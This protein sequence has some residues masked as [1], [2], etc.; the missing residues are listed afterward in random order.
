MLTPEEI[1]AFRKKGE[2]F[3]QQLW[4]SN[5]EN[6]MRQEA[7]QKW[8]EQQRAQGKIFNHNI[9]NWLDGEITTA[10]VA[11]VIGMILTALIKGQVVIWAIMYLA[12]RLRIKKV[13]QGAMD[14]DRRGDS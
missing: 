7:E 2:E 8:M 11:L 4:E 10:R 6:K 5:P 9:K 3:K 1:V 12:Y 14:A 13:K